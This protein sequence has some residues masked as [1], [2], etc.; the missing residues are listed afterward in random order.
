[1]I[2]WVA[3]KMQQSDKQKEQVVDVLRGNEDF[4]EFGQ[5]GGVPQPAFKFKKSAQMR[6]LVEEELT[7]E[8]QK[9]WAELAGEKLSFDVE[10][11]QHDFKL[12]SKYRGL[13]RR[14]GDAQPG[15]KGG[16]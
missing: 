9:V 6:E 15:G 10:K 16:K 5:A 8:Q 13:L 14:D 2:P 7:K 1:M 11:T 3:E 12:R 4:R